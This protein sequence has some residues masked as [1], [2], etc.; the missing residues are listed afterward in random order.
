M[1]TLIK[2][3]TLFTRTFTLAGRDHKNDHLE[4]NRNFK[5]LKKKIEWVLFNSEHFFNNLHN[6]VVVYFKKGLQVHLVL[7]CFA[8]YNLYMCTVQLAPWFL[9]WTGLDSD[10]ITMKTTFDFNF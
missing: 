8:W 7:S 1:S 10:I 2:W 3:S 9:K 6:I 4:I 5:I